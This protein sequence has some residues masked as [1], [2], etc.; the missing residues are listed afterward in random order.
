MLRRFLKTIFGR[1]L[2]DDLLLHHF[3]DQTNR[4]N[5]IMA[6][7]D[8]LLANARA[9]DTRLD[10]VRELIASLRT[11]IADILSGA[12]LP[13]DVQAKVDE[14]FAQLEKNNSEITQALQPPGA[15]VEVPVEPAPPEPVPT[16][17]PTT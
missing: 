6:T 10:S 15:P 9:Q 1:S 13:K 16:P 3:L 14:L 7:L 11:E 5:W 17:A 4:M 2:H 12:K 8:E